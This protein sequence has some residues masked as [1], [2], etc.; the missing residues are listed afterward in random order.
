MNAQDLAER[1]GVNVRTIQRACRDR[2]IGHM[3]IGRAI[4]FTEQQARAAEEFFTLEPVDPR[5]EV[6]N[7]DH[8]AYLRVVTPINSN[9]RVG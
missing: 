6:P 9:R 3:R 1:L 5:A 4:R 7:P 2:K 8:Q